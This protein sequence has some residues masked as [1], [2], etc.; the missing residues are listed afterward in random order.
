MSAPA[1]GR[2]IIV[3]RIT[4]GTRRMGTG[5]RRWLAGH[6][7]KGAARARGVAGRIVGTLFIAWFL[8]GMLWA[9]GTP[10]W[11]V[12]PLWLIAALVASY[13]DAADAT[14]AKAGPTQAIPPEAFVE[15]LH[16]LAQGGNVHLAKVREQLTAETG[17]PWT[18]QA[19][20][21]LCRAAG[22]PTKQVRVPGATP[23]VTTGVHRADIPPL[24]HASSGAPGN[25]VGAGHDA[26]NNTN[27]TVEP[28]GGGAAVIVKH[29]PSTRQDTRR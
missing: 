29:G 14:T 12:V 21:D 1:T 24:P 11:A 4:T 26:N 8:G 20:T 17:R 19:V 9:L 18:A 2:W 25:G 27:T 15:L 5:L 28:I 3:P 22:I 7:L 10:P 16:D 6:G 13:R 23:A